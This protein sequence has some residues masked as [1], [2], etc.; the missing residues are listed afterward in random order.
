MENGSIIIF[1]SFLFNSTNGRIPRIVKCLK[2]DYGVEHGE[3]VEQYEREIERLKK[4]I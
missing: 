4:S 1:E 3:Q 2:E